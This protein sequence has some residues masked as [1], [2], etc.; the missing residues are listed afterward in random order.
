MI[1]GLILYAPED[2]EKNKRFIDICTDKMKEAGIKLQLVVLKNKNQEELPDVEGN[3]SFCINR[4]RNYLLAQK[5]EKMGVTVFNNSLV[6]EIGND[7]WKT[8]QYAKKAGIPVLETWDRDESERYPIVI[9]S[10]RGHGGSEVFLVN[11]RKEKEKIQDMLGDECI[12]QYRADTGGRDIR[13]YII[14]REIIVSMCR[15]AKDGFKSNFS[16]GGEAAQYT[17]NN[18]EKKMVKKVANDLSSDYIGV[19][20]MYDGDRLVL[21]EIEDAVG[22]RM[23]YENTDIDIVGMYVDYVIASIMNKDKKQNSFKNKKTVLYTDL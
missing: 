5:L 8:Y 14:G 20:I 22:A 23:V 15:S 1:K 2:V 4:S 6:T 3:V 19:D 13:T 10:K 18:E 16:L 12:F 7:K 21:N 11:N 17:L 9:K